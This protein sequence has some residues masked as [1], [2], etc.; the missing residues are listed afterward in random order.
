MPGPYAPEEMQEFL[1]TFLYKSDAFLIDEVHQMDPDERLIEASLD[2][3]RPLPFQFSLNE[4]MLI[5]QPM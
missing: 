5:T 4:Q 2:T 1:D 3:R